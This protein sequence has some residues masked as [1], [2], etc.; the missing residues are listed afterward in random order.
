L[1]SATQSV[2]PAVQATVPAVTSPTPMD[3][4]PAQTVESSATQTPAK[5]DAKATSQTKEAVSLP[6]QSTKEMKQP[7]KGLTTA[8]ALSLDKIRQETMKQYSPFPSEYIKQ[9]LDRTLLLEQLMKLDSLKQEKFGQEKLK[10]ELE[11]KQDGYR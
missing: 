8:R 6:K 11:L 5:T 7:P 9:E 10:D 4:S 1:P 2:T 3:G